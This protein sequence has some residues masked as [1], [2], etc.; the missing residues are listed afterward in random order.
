MCSSDLAAI[1]VPYDH[2]NIDADEVTY[3]VTGGS[4]SDRGIG[5]ASFTLHPAGI[6]HGPYPG[7]AEAPIGAAPADDLSIMIEAVHPLRITRQAA[8]LEDPHY[9]Y[10][11]LPPEDASAESGDRE[12]EAFVD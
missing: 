4:S 10:A 11:W 8:A 9:P 5:P 7:T 3:R 1:P 2:S 6:P 12:P